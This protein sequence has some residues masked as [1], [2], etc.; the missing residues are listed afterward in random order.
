M[1][2]IA[3]L[4][5]ALCWVLVSWF[6]VG[7]GELVGNNFVAPPREMLL[8]PWV[9]FTHDHVP[10][11]FG[12]AF[13]AG[14]LTAAA[15]PLIGWALARRGGGGT[16]SLFLLLYL[17]CFLGKTLVWHPDM[18][19][20]DWDLFV[21]PWIV[22]TV[23]AAFHV[24]SLPG[25]AVWMGAVLGAQIFLLITRPIHWAEVDRRGTA[26][27]IVH[28]EEA[29]PGTQ[30]LLNNRLALDR[31]L[32]TIGEGGHFIRILLPGS[33]ERIYRAFHVR[34][35]E[36]FVLTVGRDGVEL[37]EDPPPK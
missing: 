24:M 20:E 31:P 17:F 19:E 22:T 32:R 36:S 9:L 15:I 21:F 28:Q 34:G 18:A 4:P 7:A 33:G 30:I 23:L 27:L 5:G 6:T 10:T 13:H 1:A 12:F 8:S 35:G 11:K 3:L 16:F 29:P 14:G 25:R 37:R 2:A 26:A